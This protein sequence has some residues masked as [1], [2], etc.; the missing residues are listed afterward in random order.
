MKFL[1]VVDMQVDFIA[2]SLGSKLAEA[3]VSIVVEKVKNYDGTVIF[4]VTPRHTG[5]CSIS[6]LLPHFSS[7]QRQ[8]G[9]FGYSLTFRYM[10]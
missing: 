7:E 3:I 4:T 9:I 1:I 6:M 10:F 5:V 2:G 8:T